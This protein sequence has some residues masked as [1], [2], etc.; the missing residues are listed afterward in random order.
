MWDVVR[1]RGE[2]WLLEWGRA[3]CRLCGTDGEVSLLQM[4]EAGCLLT[5][6]DKCCYPGF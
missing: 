1:W 4:R 6:S 3:G 5:V 2:V